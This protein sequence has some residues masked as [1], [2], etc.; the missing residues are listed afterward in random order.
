[1]PAF[2]K[3]A[4]RGAPKTFRKTDDAKRRT[5]PERTAPKR[6]EDFHSREERTER[7]F[8]ARPYGADREDREPMH[9]IRRNPRPQTDTFRKTPPAN[10]ALQPLP[11][12]L[13]KKGIEAARSEIGAM[14]EG[15]SS[16]SSGNF[17]IQE[18]E[19]DVSF[20]ADGKFLGFG[21]GGAATIRIRVAPAM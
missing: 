8:P 11:P 14:L 21:A 5:Y 16:L 18:V 9:V 6:S 20:N 19:I 10:D 15:I 12:Y 7:R 13:L 4:Q 3:D 2:R 1:M 17:Q